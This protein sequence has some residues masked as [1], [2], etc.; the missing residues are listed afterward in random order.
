MKRSVLLSV[1]MLSLLFPRNL[2][3]LST[4]ADQDVLGQ[5]PSL[6]EKVKMGTTFDYVFDRYLDDGSNIE[7]I[8]TGL[9]VYYKV[10]P[11]V[12]LDFSLGGAKFTQIGSVPV[13]QDASSNFEF[14]SDYGLAYGAGG[15]VDLFDKPLFGGEKEAHFFVSGGLRYTKMDIDDVSHGSPSSTLESNTLDVTY[16]EWQIAFGWNHE[17]EAISLP[18][19]FGI[20][21]SDVYFDLGGNAIVQVPN[22]SGSPNGKSPNTSDLH[23]D[24]LFGIFIGSHY[25]IFEDRLQINI[26]ARFIDENAV[27]LTGTYLF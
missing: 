22:P 1:L 12:T 13:R 17:I 10:K 19:Y 20:K 8:W 9:D 23:G 3:A 21:Y 15:K 16:F 6:P 5:S 11:D 2:Y 7:S 27:S 26:E 14:E 24:D 18:Y 4:R 25:V